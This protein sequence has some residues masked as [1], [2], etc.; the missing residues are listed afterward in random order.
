MAGARPPSQRG[1]IRGGGRAS[2]PGE[3]LGKPWGNPEETPRKPRGKR[4]RCV[5]ER[6]LESGLISGVS[7]LVTFLSSIPIGQRV[8]HIGRPFWAPPGRPD[9]RSGPSRGTPGKWRRDASGSRAATPTARRTRPSTIP[10]G[11]SSSSP[12]TS[13]GTGGRSPAA[14]AAT[15]RSPALPGSRGSA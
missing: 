15:D 7:A 14:P 8:G 9:P 3:T 6:L 5:W 10:C 2:N 12:W 13:A 1:W 4:A 11:S